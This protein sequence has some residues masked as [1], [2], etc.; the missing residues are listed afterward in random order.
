[1]DIPVGQLEVI[2]YIHVEC[3]KAGP[4]HSEGWD[5]TVTPVMECPYYLSVRN[6]D[7]QIYRNYMNLWAKRD[8]NEAAKYPYCKF[9]TLVEGIKADG[10]Y[11]QCKATAEPMKV[12]KG[13]NW[14]EDGHHRA[15]IIC[16]LFG[17]EHVVS[18]GE[19]SSALPTDLNQC[20]NPC[21]VVTPE[22][23]G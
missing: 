9:K 13:T 16:A 6:D 3:S 11:K 14:L 5:L 18:V 20:S 2:V 19:S 22:P 12:Y 23:S 21:K 4:G 15:A 8:A 17:P 10:G 1:M 7:E